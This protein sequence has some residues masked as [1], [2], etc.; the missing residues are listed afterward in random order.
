MG[1]P[2]AL[3]RDSAD[4]TFLD[5]AIT[6]LVDGGCSTVVVVLGASAE[7]AAALVPSRPEISNVVAEDWQ[8]GLSASVRAGL[9][10]AS[11]GAEAAVIHLVDLPDVTAQVVARLLD[12]AD[13]DALARAAYRGVPGHPVLIGRA[14]IAAVMSEVS[15]DA[16]AGAYL[17]RHGADLVECGDLAD[18]RDVDVPGD[19]RG[20]SR[21]GSD[22]VD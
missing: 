14:H 15:A 1:R 4:R 16:G 19:V 5:L 20:I 7:E 21:G 17:R 10:A 6:A 18:G 13:P 9:S 2:K 11:G 8:D 3:L 22:V 12:L